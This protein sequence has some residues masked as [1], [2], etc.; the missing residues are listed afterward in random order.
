MLFLC[1]TLDTYYFTVRFLLFISA[2][3]LSIRINVRFGMH[4][5]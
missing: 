1:A 5:I 4:N 3:L 2:F